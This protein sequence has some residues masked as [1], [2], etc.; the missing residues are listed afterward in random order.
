MGGCGFLGGDGSWENV[1]VGEANGVPVGAVGARGARVGVGFRELS[2][3]GSRGRGSG[4]WVS[5][6]SGQMGQVQFSVWPV[7]W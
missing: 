6:S 3:G 7:D 1:K 4:L 5:V 2:E